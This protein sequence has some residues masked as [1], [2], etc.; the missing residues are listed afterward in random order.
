MRI[1]LPDSPSLS[2]RAQWALH[3]KAPDAAGYKV[4]ACS[5]GELDN[6]N[7]TEAL[8][9]FSLGALDNLPQVSVSYLQPATRP[10]DSY[11]ALAVHW[12]AVAGQRY[13]TGVAPLDENGRQ[14]AFTSYFCAPYRQLADHAVSYLDLYEAFSAVTLPAQGGPPA[15]V[16]IRPSMPQVPAIDETEKRAAAL[17]LTGAPVCVLGAEATSTR[18]RLA[19]I[20]TV[21]ALLPYGFRSRMTAATWTKATNR[22]HKFR[23]FFSSAP[24]SAAQPDHLLHWNDPD[25]S[26]YLTG[27]AH[28]YI[29]T[30][31]EKLSSVFRLREV[32]QELRFG[33]KSA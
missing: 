4:L 22:D 24:R 2:V 26:H 6:G 32:T 31:D 30:L 28:D 1:P 7:F 9:R 5:T 21:M 25:Q 8:G 16:V 15:P 3:G 10:G 27:P 19:F 13:A 20:D 17:L 12:F 29:D 14:T 33:T 18:E 23:L 11:L